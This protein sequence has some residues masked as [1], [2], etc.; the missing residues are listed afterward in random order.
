MFLS[1]E[2]STAFSIN[3]WSISSLSFPKAILFFMVS[4]LTYI[5]CGTYPI[6]PTKLFLFVV[7]VLSSI[8]IFPLDGSKRPKIISARV[9]F[10]EPDSP[11]KA[12]KSPFFIDKD[13]SFKTFF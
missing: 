11:T 5:L 10:P 4:S 8:V 2:I 12:M 1:C 3:F 7:T 6:S 13:M 9:D